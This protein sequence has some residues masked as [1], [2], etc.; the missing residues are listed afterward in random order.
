MNDDAHQL[1]S[2]AASRP[3]DA[4]RYRYDAAGNPVDRAELGL[5]VTNSFNNLNQI[6]TGS[7]TGATLTV[8]GAVNYPV[9]SITVNG[10][11]GTVYSD[12]T[13]DVANVPAV[14]GTNTLTATYTGPAYTNAP[15]TAIDT[16]TVVLGDTAYTHDANGNLTSDATFL[17]QYD[18]ANQLTNVIRKADNTTVLQCRYDALGR[19]VEA[20]RSDGTVDRYVYFPGTF[21]V[22]AV[23]DETNTAKELYTR[24]PDLSGTLASAGGIGGILACTYATGSVLFHHADIQGNII[25]LVN[26]S[27]NFESTFRYTPFGQFAAQTEDILSRHLFS[28]KEFDHASGL[29]SY[30]YR[31][32]LPRTGRWTN[33]DPLLEKGGGNLYAFVQNNAVTYYDAFGLLEARFQSAHRSSDEHDNYLLFSASC[34]KGKRIVNPDVDYSGVEECIAEKIKK[35]LS[36]QLPPPM[37]GGDYGMLG[38]YYVGNDISLGGYYGGDD[39]PREGYLHVYQYYLNES[40]KNDLVKTFR[41]VIGDKGFL[42]NL[43]KA[44]N[45]PCDGTEVSLKAHMRTRLVAGGIRGE[46]VRILFLFPKADES[47]DCYLSH[48]KVNYDCEKCSKGPCDVL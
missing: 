29:Y 43:E 46:F 31:F 10:Q 47:Y 16:S 41:R 25:A 24:G 19:R 33:R 32:Y 9:G 34:D 7:W 28:S 4:A 38:G 18:L 1:T 11:P 27:G 6:V 42:G 21:L 20:I 23:L 13:F 35:N 48:A 3:S 12:S 40:Y 26:L 30:G 44:E 14:P 45:Y 39:I 36:K 5:D 15:M 22:L 2:V 17:Y 37:L 8:A